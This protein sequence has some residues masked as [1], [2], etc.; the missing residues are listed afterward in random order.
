MSLKQKSAKLHVLQ[1]QVSQLRYALSRKDGSL[2]RAAKLFDEYKHAMQKARFDSV[3]QPNTSDSKGTANRITDDLMRASSAKGGGGTNTDS[4]G[5]GMQML[6]GDDKPVI[7]KNGKETMSASALAQV[8]GGPA[9]K[10][11]TAIMKRTK[12]SKVGGWLILACCLFNC[13]S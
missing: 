12:D 4:G 10:E 1:K 2:H 9:A 5:G 13:L 3:K 6:G 11:N 7:D 8:I